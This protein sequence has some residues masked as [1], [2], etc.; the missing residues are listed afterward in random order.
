MA[1]VDLAGTAERY[2]SLGWALV[3]LD[4]KTPKGHG[5]QNA[6]PVDPE[7]AKSIW[8]DKDCNMG[9]VLGPSGVIDFELDGGDVELYWSLVGGDWPETPSYLT[10]SG[11]PH[12][13]FRDPGNLS[14]RT[15]DGLELRA[16]P[17]QSVLPPSIHP[18]T[19]RP[20]Q[21]RYHPAEYELMDPPKALLAF[22]AEERRGEAGDTHWRSPLEA[23]VLGEGQG[24][25]ASLLSYLGMAVNQATSAE[26]LAAMAIAYSA[27]AHDP[28]YSDETITKHAYDLWWK[29][30]E[31]VE[32]E[33]QGGLRLVKASEIVMRSIT[34]LWKPFLQR[35]AFHLWVG[36]KGAG[37]GTVLTWL[38]AQM[39]VGFL[40][41]ET[42]T[43]LDPKGVLWISTEDSFDIDVKPRFLAQGGDVERLLCVRQRVLLP[44]D[45]EKLRST[46]L[47]HDVGMVI[48]DPIISTLEKGSDANDEASVVS[49]I[50]CL[51]ALADELD[52]TIIGVRHLGKSLDRSPLE[53]VLGSAAWVNTP[54]AVLG[55]A[56]DEETKIATLEILAGNRV[57]GRVSWDFKIDEATVE[58][59]N[60][61][62]SKAKSIGLS[63]SSMAEVLKREKGSK[64][65]AIKLWILELLES[66]EAIA[67]TDLVEPCVEKFGVGKRSLG[68]ACTE[69]KEEGEIR[70]VPGEIDPLTGRKVEGSKWKIVRAIPEDL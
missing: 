37:K 22:F 47:A 39:T 68:R 18:D 70:Y 62:V 36:R 64:I 1:S 16:G 61:P 48:I 29:W 51:N 53:S 67:Q 55:L 32:E 9:L 69:L 17:H 31:D 6:L 3:Q 40:D 19:G 11:K 27:V 43:V 45:E 12:I 49:A 56:Q 34:F 26:Q 38:A 23:G 59:V 4:G 15:R 10:G 46:C 30:H 2:A 50:G 21:W 66:G 5:W 65:P 52:L 57:R 58:G 7:S 44:A 20:Y 41:E 13:L 54:R 14:R 33:Q 35:S 63:D 24:R 25:Y 60:E 42:E 28:P 8:Q